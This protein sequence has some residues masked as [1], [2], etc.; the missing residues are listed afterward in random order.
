MK[1]YVCM[2]ERTCDPSSQEAEAGES[3]FEGQ[4]E[5]HGEILCVKRTERAEP[6]KRLLGWYENRV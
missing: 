4:S 5:Q 2:V 6:V 3:G 1:N